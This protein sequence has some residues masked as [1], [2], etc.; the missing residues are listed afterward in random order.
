M[1]FVF[2]VRGRLPGTRR[3]ATSKNWVETTHQSIDADRIHSL[4][5]LKNCCAH[6]DRRLKEIRA[7]PFRLLYC[8][9]AVAWV[10]EP[11]WKSLGY[12]PKFARVPPPAVRPRGMLCWLC[13]RGM[14]SLASFFS[15]PRRALVLLRRAA[16][17]TITHTT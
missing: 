9:V 15:G 2:G 13:S 7:P 3:N 6:D 16:V 5:S 10:A 11:E 12:E 1:E 8:G 14:L 17:P 4:L